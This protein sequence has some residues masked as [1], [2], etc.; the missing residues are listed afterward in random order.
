MGARVKSA[1]WLVALVAAV[2]APRVAAQPGGG[3]DVG[4]AAFAQSGCAVCHGENGGGTAA[5]PSLAGG[6]LTVADFTTAVRRGQRTMPAYGAQQLPDDRLA[7]IHA[8]LESQPTPSVAAGS[9]DAGARLFAAYGCASCHANE[10]QGGVTGPR[11]GPE[12]ITF[13]RFAWYV[14]QPTLQM[15]PYSTAVVSERDLADI[16]AFVESRA[17]PPPLDSISLLA[18]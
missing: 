1:V 18:P 4:A 8:Y 5:G 12:P 6:R 10:A 17:R 2:Q 14:R 13:A 9:A 7:A 16:Y 11:L 15:P 3:A